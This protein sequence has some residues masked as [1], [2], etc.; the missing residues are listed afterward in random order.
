MDNRP[1]QIGDRVRLTDYYDMEGVID[2][3]GYGFFKIK[4]DRPVP[5]YPGPRIT[6]AT[7]EPY[8]NM[9]LIGGP[10]KFKQNNDVNVLITRKGENVWEIDYRNTK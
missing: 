1:F 5:N 4:L 6:H 2:N 10:H 7:M 9:E 8:G 3:Y